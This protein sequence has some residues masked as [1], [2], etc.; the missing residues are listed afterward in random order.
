[1]REGHGFTIW[2]RNLLPLHRE[3]GKTHGTGGVSRVCRMTG[4]FT[5]LLALFFLTN[6]TSPS[7]QFETSHSNASLKKIIAGV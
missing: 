6:H 1:M 7:L 5:T 3:V 2:T 4:I